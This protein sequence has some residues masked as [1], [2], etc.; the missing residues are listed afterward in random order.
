M[1][2][3]LCT[4]LV[5]A[6]TVGVIAATSQPEPRAER[7]AD[8]RTSTAVAGSTPG[9]GPGS[10]P[11]STPGSSPGSSPASASRT[12]PSA[13]DRP[14]PADATVFRGASGWQMGVSPSWK[15]FDIPGFAEEAA[16]TTGGGTASFANNVNVVVEKPTVAVDLPAYVALSVA[17]L[18]RSFDKTV[19]VASGV[20][21]AA[22]H[23]YG[24]IQYTATINGTPLAGVGYAVKIESGWALATFV[25]PPGLFD[26]FGPQ[27]EPFLQTLQATR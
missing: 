11:G 10:T 26:E 9:S 12:F 4:L 14:V 21:S 8:V 3:A 16:W 22:D 20:Y 6:L 5:V 23:D 24:R 2:A 27:V 17:N 15:K 19:I 13:P 25:T 1:L 18:R 7:A